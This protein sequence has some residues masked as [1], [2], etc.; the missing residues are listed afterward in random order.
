MIRA[1]I[2]GRLGADPVERTTRGG[3]PMV[4]ASVAVD[5]GRPGEDPQT[6]W[7]NLV[8]FGTAAEVLADH[9]KG[10]LVAVMGP[11]TR[12]AFTGRDGIERCSWSVLAEAILSI[13][14]IAPQRRSPRRRPYTKPRAVDQPSEGPPLPDEA[15]G[16]LGRDRDGR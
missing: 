6:E 5:V 16:D 10:D 2:N 9:A 1:A 15:V 14:S 8:A 12:S 7:I 3:K 11:L 13:R 4:T